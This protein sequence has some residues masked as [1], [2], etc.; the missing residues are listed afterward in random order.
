MNMKK[1]ANVLAYYTYKNPLYLSNDI[2]VRMRFKDRLKF[3]LFGENCVIRVGE[4]LIIRHDDFIS[5]G[6]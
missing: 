4:E 5:K 2:R 3:L 1:V 6:E